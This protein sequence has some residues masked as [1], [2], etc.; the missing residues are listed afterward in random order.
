MIACSHTSALSVFSGCGVAGW[1]CSHL[2][3]R[4]VRTIAPDTRAGTPW[5]HARE[6]TRWSGVMSRLN[7]PHRPPGLNGISAARAAAA[8]NPARPSACQS[9]RNRTIAHGD[10]R[11][12]RSDHGQ[13]AQNRQ[14]LANL[15]LCAQSCMSGGC[16]RNHWCPTPRQQGEKQAHCSARWLTCGPLHQTRFAPSWEWC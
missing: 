10:S 7:V 3:G 11:W 8:G 16:Q 15:A 2:H 5:T 14:L 1:P 4:V 6:M 9:H 12:R 13:A